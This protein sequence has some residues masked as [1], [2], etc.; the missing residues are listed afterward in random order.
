MSVSGASIITIAEPGWSNKIEFRVG[1]VRA[2]WRVN[3]SGG[4]SALI[5]AIAA[6]DQGIADYTDLW[7]RWISASGRIWGGICR[8]VAIRFGQTV[9][10]SATSFVDELRNIRTGVNYRQAMASAGTIIKRA[11]VDAPGEFAIFDDIDTDDSGPLISTAWRADN[12]FQVVDR[13]ARSG[14]QQYIDHTNDDWTRT[15]SVRET[16]GVDKSADIILIEGKHFGDGDM[17]ISTK[18]LAN[19]L[20]AKSADADWEDAPG[21][22]VEKTDSVEER[23]LRQAVQRYYGIHSVSGLAARARQELE[24]MSLPRIPVSIPLRADEP[25]LAEIDPGDIVRLWSWSA[26]FRG[27]LAI[28]QIVEDEDSGRCTLVG[29]AVAT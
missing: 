6:W 2:D 8:E 21:A 3:G 12:L 18:A 14:N 1:S 25:Q 26:N 27:T 28:S 4:F 13:I 9:E 19:N 24:T 16:V 29:T 5:P 22:I 20:L 15:L 23:G 11:I 10:L 17:V 7:V